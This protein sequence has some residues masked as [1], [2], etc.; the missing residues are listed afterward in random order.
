MPRPEVLICNGHGQWTRT[1][2]SVCLRACS[3]AGF[4]ACQWGPSSSHGQV[5][6]AAPALRVGVE[7]VGPTTLRAVPGGNGKQSACELRR[8]QRARSAA[9]RTGPAVPQGG[10]DGLVLVR[11]RGPGPIPVLDS[12]KSD[13]RPRSDSRRG[14]APGLLATGACQCPPYPLQ[15][16]FHGDARCR[17]R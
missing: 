17:R 14:S 1:R 10:G 2:R 13:T 9:A 8:L 12:Q 5:G 7:Q 4:G 15:R 3:P 16:A 11:E 6:S